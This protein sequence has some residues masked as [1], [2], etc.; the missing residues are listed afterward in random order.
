[1]DRITVTPD[2]CTGC[3][4]CEMA[5][6]FHHTDSFSPERSRIRVTKDE[7]RGI[8]VPTLCR[9]CVRPPCVEWC[10]ADALRQSP[11]GIVEVDADRCYGCGICVEVCPYH[12]VNMD[13][14]RGLPLIC[15]TCGGNPACVGRCATQALRFEHPERAQA[16]RRQLLSVMRAKGVDDDE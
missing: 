6:S 15:N 14:L 10:P 2:R 3:R 16:R 5:C 1:M 12:A 4:A 11:T 8:D 7:F 9:Q 13:R